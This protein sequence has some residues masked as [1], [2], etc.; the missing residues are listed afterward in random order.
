MSRLTPLFPA[1]VL[2]TALVLLIVAGLWWLVRFRKVPEARAFA[3]KPPDSELARERPPVAPPR[4]RPPVMPKHVSPSDGVSLDARFAAF[5]SHL[6]IAY[7]VENRRNGDLWV[8]D[9]DEVTSSP[10]Y[11]IKS[12]RVSFEPPETAVLACWW[13]YQPP[14]A[15]TAWVT[16]PVFYGTRVAAGRKYAN[17]MRTALPL[18]VA[19]SFAARAGHEV[20]CAQ[21]RFEVAVI[22]DWPEVVPAHVNGMSLGRF[23][24]KALEAQRVLSAETRPFRAP[25]DFSSRRP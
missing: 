19:G 6:E 7:T 16:P 24:L 15:G 17:T 2:A 12:P 25:L 20:V 11:E 14:P 5:A 8:L 23:Y 3:P 9:I 22:L 13:E 4:N 10:H 1:A 18:A 21:A